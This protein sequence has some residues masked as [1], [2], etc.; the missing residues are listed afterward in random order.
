MKRVFFS[1]LITAALFAPIGAT[2][3]AAVK[4]EPSPGFEFRAPCGT[5]QFY[6]QGT[7]KSARK[8][9]A[10]LFRA[11]GTAA[12]LEAE[13]ARFQANVVFGELGLSGSMAHAESLTGS[14]VDPDFM[15][16]TPETGEIAVLAISMKNKETGTQAE[17]P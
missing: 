5:A 17:Q 10:C 4:Y 3:G 7:L 11:D 2:Q 9:T 8:H 6:E 14:M 13:F 1:L 12:D 15:C 16:L